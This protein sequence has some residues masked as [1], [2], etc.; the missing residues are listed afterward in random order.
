[1]IAGIATGAGIATRADTGTGI[2]NGVRAT[3]IAAPLRDGTATG[4][5]PGTGSDAD[6]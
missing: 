3:D 5:D 1:M 6:A 4:R 2:I